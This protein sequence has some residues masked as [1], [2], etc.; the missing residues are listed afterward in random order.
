MKEKGITLIA[1]II[2]IIVL[3]ILASISIALITG[4]NGIIT[5]AWEAKTSTQRE[6]AIEKVKI[7]VLGSYGIDGKINENDLNQNLSNVGGLTTNLPI[8]LPATVTVDGFEITI[9]ADGNVTLENDSTTGGETPTPPVFNEDDVTI[10]EVEPK[11]TDKYGWKVKN[12]TV[13]AEETGAWRL[14][15]QDTNYAYLI[16][17]NCIGNYKPS[18]YYASY[19]NGASVSTIGQKLNPIISS[20]FTEANRGNEIKTTAWLTDTSDTSMWT[21]YK[22]KDA[23]F[24]IGSPTVELFAASYNNRSNKTYYEI[25]VTLGRYGYKQ[26]TVEKNDWLKVEE[27][28]GIYN[29]S[30]ITSWWLASPFADDFGRGLLV[31][32]PYKSILNS[33]VTNPNPVRPIVGIQTSVFDSK[34]LNSLADE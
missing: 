32:G 1:L 12:Y 13:K 4:E 34:Y 18:D 3:L 24:A 19:P 22:N 21:K 10:G 7:A 17:D 30:D 20:L 23:V 6:T 8:T 16:S 14:F 5:K 25:T 31:Y 33:G 2:T 26:N 9:G 29:K 27:N 15:Y 11:N 28:H